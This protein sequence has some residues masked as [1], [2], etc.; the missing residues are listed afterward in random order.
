MKKSLNEVH[1]AVMGA[2]DVDGRARCDLF[3]EVPDKRVSTVAMASD[4]LCAECLCPGLP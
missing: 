3:R 4:S 2:K 1:K